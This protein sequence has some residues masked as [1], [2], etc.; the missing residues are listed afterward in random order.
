MMDQEF[1]WIVE[2]GRLA[3]G[4]FNTAEDA[5][6]FA[7]IRR[8]SCEAADTAPIPWPHEF[9]V[10]PIKNPAVCTFA[11]TPNGRLNEAT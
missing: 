5:S 1:F 7:N 3:F 4:P 11:E 8:R 10:R 9:T 2:S 6:E